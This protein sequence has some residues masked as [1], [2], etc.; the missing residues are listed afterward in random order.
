[1]LFYILSVE[2]TR[3]TL[4]SLNLRLLNPA[5]CLDSLTIQENFPQFERIKGHYCGK[6]E[7]FVIDIDSETASLTLDIGELTEDMPSFLEMR[8]FFTDLSK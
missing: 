2:S 4:L 1:M 3:L 7:N 5:K 8:A 6:L